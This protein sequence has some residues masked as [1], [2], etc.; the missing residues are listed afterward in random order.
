MKS[1]CKGC[2]HNNTKPLLKFYYNKYVK[3]TF[4]TCPVE[5]DDVV[6]ECFIKNIDINWEEFEKWCRE[7]GFS[8]GDEAV[9]K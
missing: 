8:F 2:P 6:W 4:I 9:G 3:P 5:S 7:H 1:F